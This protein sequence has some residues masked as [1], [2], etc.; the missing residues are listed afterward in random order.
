MSRYSPLNEKQL[1][2]LR[3]I[4]QGYPQRDWPDHTHKSSALALQ[5][6]GLVKVSKKGGTWSAAITDD[7][8]YYLDHGRYS[9]HIERRSRKAATSASTTA[10]SPTALPRAKVEINDLIERVQ[11]TGGALRVEDPSIELR[12]AYRRAINHAIATGEVPQG[13]LL[14]YTG[15]DR[16]DLTIRLVASKDRPQRR[17]RSATVPIPDAVDGNNDAAARLEQ[18]SRLDVSASARTRAL[19]IVQGIAEEAGR[20]GHGFGLRPDSHPGFR[21]SIGE[22]HYDFTVYEEYDHVE[23]YP[24]EEVGTKKYPWQ[25]VSPRTT[26]LPSGRLAIQLQRGTVRGA[27]R[28]AD[29]TRWT[30]IDKLPEVFR[31]IEDAAHTAREERH[32]RQEEERRLHDQWKSAVADARGRYL[33]ELNRNRV[34]D[35]AEAWRRAHDLRSYAA[36]LRNH[37]DEETDATTR[38]RIGDWADW[39][40]HE[41]EEIDPLKELDELGFLTPDT[42]AA[43]DLDPFMPRGLTARHPPRANRLIW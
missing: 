35:Q 29:R 22:D 17:E 5:G 23:H 16:G 30:L 37:A 18:E 13:Y 11:I 42:I 33:T 9:D 24:D 4:A 20:R 28:W 19:R 6:R 41:A 27:S 43:E 26:A 1:E 40:Q 21:I 15:R 25:R 36:G 10:D 39:A 14:Q 7:G 3:W 31:R 8:R 38:R 2:V 32:R 34:R 12:A